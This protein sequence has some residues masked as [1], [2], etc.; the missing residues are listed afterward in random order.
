[1]WFSY[2]PAWFVVS[3]TDGEDVEAP[4]LPEWSADRAMATLGIE[5]I[6]FTMANGNVQGYS[7]GNAIAINPVAANP[8]KT[9][10]HE[11][12]HEIL[13][14]ANGELFMDV[15]ELPSNLR[16][17]EAEAVALIVVESLGQP[18]ADNARG[19]IQHWL[20]A[21]QAIPESSAQ[22]IFAAADRILRAGHPA[23]SDSQEALSCMTTPPLPA[24]ACP[25]PNAARHGRS[26]G[27][28]ASLLYSF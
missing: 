7:Q 21:G 16:E 20:G 24:R 23:T 1:M 9:T 13:H 25:V 10:V 6:P 22:R 5:R 14:Q 26:S 3:Q 11:L 15:A 4:A 17:V 2:R 8:F 12:A 27:V 18:G 19:Y 28:E